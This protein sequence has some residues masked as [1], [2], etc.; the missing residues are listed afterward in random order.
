MKKLFVLILLISF[1]GLFAQGVDWNLT[2]AGSRALGMGGAF[3]GVADDA[4]AIT[5]NP[6]GLYNLERMEA[7]IVSQYYSEDYEFGPYE[8]GYDTFVMNFASVAVPINFGENKVTV[9][10]AF[11]R[12]MELYEYTDHGYAYEELS[13]AASTVNIGAGSRFMN[14]LAV[15]FAA[16]IWLGSYTYEY[17]EVGYDEENTGYFSGFNMGLGRMIDLNYLQSPVPLKLGISVKTPFDLMVDE[18]YGE[19]TI[20]MPLMLGAGFSYRIGEMLTISAD[21]ETRNY[22]DKK[23]IYVDDDGEIMEDVLSHGNLN[24]FRIGT[25]YLFL[26][27]FAVIPLRLGFQNVPTTNYTAENDQIVGNGISFGTGFIFEKFAIDI[28]SY[29]A[30]FETDFGFATY[31]AERLRAGISGIIYF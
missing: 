25:E 26:S 28:F 23:S 3:I 21:F 24:Q 13:G 5:W 7:S 16:N 8:Q 27:D 17:S 12:Q 4:T 20:E 19:T 1:C 15:G 6:A 9:A 14:V 11:Q 30:M 29:Y 22:Q 18:E 10:L 2:G 31:N